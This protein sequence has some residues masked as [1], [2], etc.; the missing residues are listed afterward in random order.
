MKKCIALFLALALM[1]ILVA[2]CAED[3]ENEPGE[4]VVDPAAPIESEEPETEPESEPE[5]ETE[6]E[7]EPE[8]E[9]EPAQP[10]RDGDSDIDTLD[11]RDF[12]SAENAVPL[13]QWVRFKTRN[14]VSDESEYIYIRIVSVS[15]NEAEVQAALDAYDGMWDLT[16]SEEMARDIEFGLLTYE[17]HVPSGFSA[18]DWGVTVP[19]IN[20]RARSLD[21]GGFRLGG[22]SFI[23][24]GS[25]YSMNINRGS[26]R[27]QP[28][29]T[30]TEQSLFSI[31]IAFDESE[32]IFNF[33]WY[34]GE[35]NTENARELYFFAQ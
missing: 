11:A 27:P 13:G 6:P 23:G 10:A 17:V 31:L 29:D 3:A 25:S 15:R 19:S 32:Y 7:S 9:A 21:G 35:I 14:H 16:L 34:D 20:L 33:R 18:N 28:G 5:T 22:V 26:D 1:F 2:A 12:D 24:V 30:I 4:V 8:L